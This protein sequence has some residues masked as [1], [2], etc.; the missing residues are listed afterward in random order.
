M[1]EWLPISTAPKDGTTILVLDELYGKPWH[2]ECEWNSVEW[3]H[4][5]GD[6]WPRAMPTHWMPL[7][8]PPLETEG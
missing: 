6:A 2:Y 8:P 5:F 4:G 7:P 1:N 3:Y